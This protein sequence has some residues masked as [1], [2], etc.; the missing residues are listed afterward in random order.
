MTDFIRLD[1]SDNV[2]TATRVLDVGYAV[3]GV[4]TRDLIP[5]GHKIAT[6][7]I[8]AGQQ[9]TKYA[10]FIGTGL[11]GHCSQGHHV[12]I[13]TTWHSRATEADL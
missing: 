2:V 10:Q 11:D 1:A 5:S 4:V 12:H 8:A 3:E 7:P 13:R 9:V 6:A